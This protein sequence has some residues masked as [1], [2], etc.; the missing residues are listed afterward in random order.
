MRVSDVGRRIAEGPHIY[1]RD[2]WYYLL[3]AEGGTQALHRVIIGRSRSP[4]GPYEYPE[5]GVNPLVFNGEHPEVRHA[6]HADMAQGPDGKWWAVM[7]AVR[8]Q[9]NGVFPLGRETFLCPVEWKDDG[10]PEMN[11]GELLDLVVRAD[12]PETTALSDWRDDFDSEPCESAPCHANRT[13]DNLERGWYHLR[14][15]VGHEYSLRDRPSH[16][17]L[18][19]G[20]YTLRDAE[21]PSAIFRK[22]ITLNGL[23][24]TIIDF[25]PQ[26]TYEEAGTVV[27]LACHSHISL[28]LRRSD[29][30]VKQVVARWPAETDDNFEVGVNSAGAKCQGD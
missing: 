5:S 13:D 11:H 19:G 23:W 27:Y 30:G 18:L 21:C 22:Q 3:T 28:F 20:G 24:S 7:L 4:L 12:L 1:K 26:T 9:A 2:G 29:L 25:D 16:L 17:T 6:G 14:T 10:W 8:P 15:P